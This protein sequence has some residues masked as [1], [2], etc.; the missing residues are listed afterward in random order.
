MIRLRIGM[1]MVIMR[2]IMPVV[3]RMVMGMVM[4]LIH[5]QPA[6]TGAECGA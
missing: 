6:F 1:V 3:M 2:M 5:I 4:V